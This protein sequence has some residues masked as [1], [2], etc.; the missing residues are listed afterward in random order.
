MFD[1]FDDFMTLKSFS[2]PVRVINISFSQNASVQFYV[3]WPADEKSAEH[4]RDGNRDLRERVIAS[5]LRRGPSSSFFLNL[6]VSF[7]GCANIG[8]IMNH[9]L[10]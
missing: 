4:A 1:D 9:P 6:E 8:C 2:S 10:E 5:C 7:S 3:W